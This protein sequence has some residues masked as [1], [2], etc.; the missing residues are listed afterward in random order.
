MWSGSNIFF[1]FCFRVEEELRFPPLK[2][3]VFDK[4]PAYWSHL[5]GN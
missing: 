5:Y 1:L 3:A 4:M 2:S